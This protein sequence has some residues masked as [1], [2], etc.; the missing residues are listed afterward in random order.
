MPIFEYVCKSCEHRFEALVRSGKLP[1][2]PSCQSDELS[3]QLSVFAMSS[4][5]RPEAAPPMGGCGTCGDPR[6]PGA[7]KL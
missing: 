6:G 4:G 7:C 5:S 2:C 3:R 1:A